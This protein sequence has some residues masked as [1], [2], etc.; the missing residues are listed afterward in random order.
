MT[1]ED[2][3]S[4]PYPSGGAN[5]DSLYLTLKTLRQWVQTYRDVHNEVVGREVIPPV[6]DIP[7]RAAYVSQPVTVM[8]GH[9]KLLRNFREM[10]D[11]VVRVFDTDWGNQLCVQQRVVILQASAIL[12]NNAFV[13]YEHREATRQS[14]FAAM[15][16]Q[17]EAV[18]RMLAEHMELK[19]YDPTEDT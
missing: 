13:P 18:Q 3:E 19:T 1:I 11:H 10:W 15:Q 4:P 6:G 9:W 8:F 2:V 7:D 17:F 14:E 12:I 16:R 5:P